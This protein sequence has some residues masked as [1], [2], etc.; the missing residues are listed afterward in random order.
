MLND[1]YHNRILDGENSKNLKTFFMLNELLVV[2]VSAFQGEKKIDKNTKTNVW[3]T[4][5]AG[6]IPTT[7]MVVA[8]TV[9]EQAGLEIGST[10]L[11]MINE[12]AE[13]E[14]EG[15]M[16]RTFNY[17]VLGDVKPMEIIGLRKELGKAGTVDTAP[18][19]INGEQPNMSTSQLGAKPTVDLTE[20]TKN[21]EQKP[22][23]NEQ[24][25]AAVVNK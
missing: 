13:R 18:L 7:A 23:V 5:I 17:T 22:A 6:I 16:R 19:P 9:A 24:K 4:P 1:T 10:K 11:V 25:P 20:G 21:E 3:L 8:G 12:T 2:S 14:V 15:V